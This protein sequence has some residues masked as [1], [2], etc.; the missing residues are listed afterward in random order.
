MDQYNNDTMDLM[1]LL[2]RRERMTAG[3][4]TESPLTRVEPINGPQRSR[5]SLVRV[6]AATKWMS[7]QAPMP[8]FRAAD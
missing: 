5:A 3:D 1:R 8:R 2:E 7:K 4:N 6:D